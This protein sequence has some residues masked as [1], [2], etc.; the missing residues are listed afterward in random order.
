MV[1]YRVSAL[2]AIEDY[3]ESIPPIARGYAAGPALRVL[4]IRNKL[5]LEHV[6]YNKYEVGTPSEVHPALDSSPLDYSPRAV[7]DAESSEERLTRRYSE[8]TDKYGYSIP[9]EL[10]EAA[11]IVAE[12]TPRSPST[13]NHSAIAALTDERYGTGIQD[14]YVPPQAYHT[15]NGLSQIVLDENDSMLLR[16]NGTE[17][18]LKKRASS[19][20]WMA[21]M[22][23]RGSS[24]Y[25]P[26][27]Y[28]RNVMD[29]G[30]KALQIHWDWAWTMQDVVIESCGSGIVIVGGAGGP[31]STGQGVGSFALVDA[32]IANTP[33]GI[34]T[35]LYNKNST[36]LFLQNVGFYNTQNAILDD[37]ANKALIPGGDQII[38]DSWGFGMVNDPQGARFVSGT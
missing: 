17:G 5:R 12:S 26:S 10:R 20:W 36:A 21:T 18:D 25:T 32:I 38:L 34:T 29:Y 9:D 37:T 3:T 19:S 1:T 33:T 24:P 35:T 8:S 28:K 6:Q 14:T 11:K 31:F 4:K 23:Q 15:Y 2:L 27:G 7:K 16:G 30:A 22:T 13:G